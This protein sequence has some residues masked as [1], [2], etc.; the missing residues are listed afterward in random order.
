MVNT[1]RHPAPDCEEHGVPH[2]A[3]AQPRINYTVNA[4]MELCHAQTP[5]GTVCRSTCCSRNTVARL[6]RGLAEFHRKLHQAARYVTAMIDS[7]RDSL[8]RRVMTIKLYLL[9]SPG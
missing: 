9:K 8:H 1:S 7:V 2:R 6:G 3:V 4:A 5:G